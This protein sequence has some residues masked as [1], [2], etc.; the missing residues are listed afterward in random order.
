MRASLAVAALFGL[1]LLAAG[2]A[3]GIGVTRETIVR[4]VQSP[5][6]Y[7]LRV[8][9]EAAEL[10]RLGLTTLEH[11]VANNPSM[12]IENVYAEA[13]IVICAEETTPYREVVR[14][15]T[16]LHDEA[17]ARVRVAVAGI[18]CPAG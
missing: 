14:V 12:H 1:T 3:Y 2:A 9:Q 10:P 17:F 13:P 15:L 18:G 7:D 8:D 16:A 11:A 5:D 6:G 4:L